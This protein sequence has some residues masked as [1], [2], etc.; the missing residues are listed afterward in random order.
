MVGNKIMVNIIDIEP[1]PDNND[2]IIGYYKYKS[3][4]SP[5]VECVREYP[6]YSEIINRIIK[7]KIQWE[8]E[9]EDD[10]PKL[11]NGKAV[12]LI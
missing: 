8:F 10:S 1:K 5:I 7:N 4:H 6:I 2:I 11:I 3:S 12:I 9:M